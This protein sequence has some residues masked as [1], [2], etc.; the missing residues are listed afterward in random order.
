MFFAI[1]KLLMESVNL[2]E[3]MEKWH[4]Q[5]DSRGDVL[6]DTAHHA[7]ESQH[8]YGHGYVSYEALTM[9]TCSHRLSTSPNFTTAIYVTTNENVTVDITIVVVRFEDKEHVICVNL[10]KIPLS[11]GD[12]RIPFIGKAKPLVNYNSSAYISVSKGDNGDPYIPAKVVA[13]GLYIRR[14]DM[15]KLGRTILPVTPFTN[16]VYINGTTLVENVERGPWMR[17]GAFLWLLKKHYKDIITRL[18]RPGGLM[19]KRMEMNIYGDGN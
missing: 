4:A 8:D 18:Y 9:G 17:Y 13:I 2:R 6:R 12:N 19:A 10:T 3:F 16:F 7:I 14:F 15:D 5:R 1:L 11:K